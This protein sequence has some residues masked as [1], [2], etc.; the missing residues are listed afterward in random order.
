MEN[1]INVNEIIVQMI[2]I[3]INTI[4]AIAKNIKHKL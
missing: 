2:N 4:S 1:K 3:G